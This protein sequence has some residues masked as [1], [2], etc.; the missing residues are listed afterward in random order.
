MKSSAHA[1]AASQADD[2][3]TPQP[4]GPR[5]P[6][7]NTP[8]RRQQILEVATKH[9]SREGYHRASL[10]AIATDAG[11]SHAAV[12][13]HFPTKEDLLSRVV[14]EHHRKER[15]YLTE[16]ARESSTAE[17]LVEALA[18][19]QKSPEHARLWVVLT[20]EAS[21]PQHPASRFVTMRLAEF[22]SL[23][24]HALQDLRRTGSLRPDLDL[25]RTATILLSLAHGLQVQALVDPAVD[26]VEEFSVFLNGHVL[27]PS[28][29]IGSR[30]A[31]TDKD[32]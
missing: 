5:G 19:Q 4:R 12:M 10:R 16:R 28:A 17:A 20:A 31:Q 3:R 22:R 7:E 29:R 32:P 21:N 18:H 23:T 25:R 15:E 6:Y 1:N 27:M 14:E 9:F 26:A 2:L 11:I 24:M 13:R 30:R 8:A